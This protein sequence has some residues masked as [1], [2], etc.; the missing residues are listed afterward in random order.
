[1]VDNYK[2][3]LFKNN[4][5]AFDFIS[6]M[7]NINIE[8]GSILCGIVVK[9]FDDDETPKSVSIM[10]A[11]PVDTRVAFAELDKEQ[12]STLQ[13][14]DLV[15]CRV[16]GVDES[17]ED[18]TVFIVA[19]LAICKPELTPKGILEFKKVFTNT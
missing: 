15:Y 16:E 10:L 13:K 14:D 18:M 2:T 7:S 4:I 8:I 19:V 9:I 6:T 3:I 11:H 5:D 17:Y 1:M 12:E